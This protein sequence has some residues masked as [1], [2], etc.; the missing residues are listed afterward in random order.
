MIRTVANL[1][2]V[3]LIVCLTTTPC[4]LAVGVKLTLTAMFTVDSGHLT[5][6]WN[7][8]TQTDPV[9]HWTLTVTVQFMPSD[10]ML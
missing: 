8:K 2:P 3:S 1:T 10:V 6:G 7:T 4:G 5:G 9:I